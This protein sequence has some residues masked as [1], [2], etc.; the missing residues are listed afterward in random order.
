MASWGKKNRE[1]KLESL[2]SRSCCWAYSGVGSALI[3][4]K[5]IL[6]QISGFVD[7][8]VLAA[9]AREPYGA[10]AALDP[11]PCLTVAGLAA[12]VLIEMRTVIGCVVLMFADLEFAFVVEMAEAGVDGEFSRKIL[13]DDDPDAGI[14]F[15][16][17]QLLDIV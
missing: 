11:D 4:I 9:I 8:F 14:G 1:R 3:C 15:E 5:R 12:V 16:N 13:I 10:E 6:M 7:V 17:G 2:S